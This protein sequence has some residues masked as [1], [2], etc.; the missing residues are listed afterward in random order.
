MGRSCGPDPVEEHPK[1]RLAT[2]ADSNRQHPMSDNL[3]DSAI[4]LLVER[5]FPMI[6]SNG[7]EKSPCVAWKVFQTRLPT[8][9][10]LSVWAKKFRPERW[11]LVT[12]RLSRR[13]VVD[14]D[15]EQGREWMRKW[16]I[17]P[18]LRT[19]SGGYHWHL[20][21]PGWRVPTLNAKSAKASW[22][23]PGVDIRGDGGFALVLGCNSNGPYVQL[24]ELD[25][26]SFEVL[27]AEVRTFL[28]KHGGKQGETSK[29]TSPRAQPF[30]VGGN[31]VDPERLIRDALAIAPPS[32]RN[33]AGFWLACQLRDNGDEFGAAEGAMRSYLSRVSST[34][35]KG[36]REPYTER[37]MLETLSQA[38][39]A[40]AREPWRKQSSRPHHEAA[41]S[42]AAREQVRRA[43]NVSPARSKVAA[44]IDDANSPESIDL[45][46]G[47]T[48]EPLVGHTGDP[49]SRGQYSRVPREVLSDRRLKSRDLRVYAVLAGACWQGSVVSV[50]KR[51]I[52]KRAPCAE[53]L[54]VP[55]LKR[56]EA[57]GH[58][59]KV[60]VKRGQRGLYHL[61]SAVF[62]Q[63]QRA[64]IE[65]LIVTPDSKRRLATVRR[66]PGKARTAQG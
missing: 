18:H 57:T 59:Q 30:N 65:E 40:P 36:L 43:E 16:G 12:G 17:K 47:H 51:L 56:L 4:R 1:T 38:Y 23:W 24:R 62:G 46:V 22:P 25:P 54:V 15:G 52:A 32:G 45:Y 33:N 13:V 14:F 53:R 10:Q 49:L 5:G 28:Q 35:T 50:G 60:P 6:P 11:G 34:N 44:H 7:T 8:V 26:E 42:V 48:G 3:T 64:G 61:V 19:G 39:S 2:T 58:I 55:S 9:E 20:I 63:K 37:E 66:D 31:R 29:R 41:P 27:P 21:H